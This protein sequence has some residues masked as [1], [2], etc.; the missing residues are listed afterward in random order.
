MRV[1]AAGLALTAAVSLLVAFGFG[2][3]AAI[4]GLTLG[5]LATGIELL[6]VRALRRGMAQPGTTG[7]FKAVGAGMLLRL[8]GLL[9][10]AGLVIWQRALFPPV[11]AA[12]GF[13]GVLLPLLF[14][15][16]RFVR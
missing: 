14:L 12:I 11:P 5:A 8:G 10:F 7:F 4:P 9:V 13:L 1:L 15:E 3:G 2:A 6:A 16:V